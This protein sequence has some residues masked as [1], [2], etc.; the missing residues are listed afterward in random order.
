[1]SSPK[2]VN[3]EYKTSPFPALAAGKSGLP[4]QLP[5]GGVKSIGKIVFTGNMIAGDTITVN[6]KVFTCMASGATGEFQFNVD[7]SLSASLDSLI[8]VL[9]A[10][11]D[12]LV[13]YATY[14]KTD[15]NTAV[16]STSDGYAYADNY[17]SKA[18][19][20]THST[21][22]VT[23]PASGRNKGEIS[24]ETEST[25]ISHASS[26]EYFTLAEG[27]EFQKKTIVMTGAGVAEIDGDF[28]GSSTTLTFDAGEYAVL[29][30]LNGEWKA[31]ANTGALT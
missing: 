19:A 25:N 6:T 10:C 29:Q 3:P 20:S 24:L 27:D 13:S 16:T 5:R 1:M 9:N 31:V 30:Y 4:Q 8:T 22:V 23:Q 14:T 2:Y 11:T 21:V 28:A 12:P 17:P 26:T 15:T 7:I 18:L